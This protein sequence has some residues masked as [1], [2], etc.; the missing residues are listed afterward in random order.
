[1]SDYGKVYLVGAGIGSEEHITVRGKKLLENA[2][3]IVYDRLLNN[4]LINKSDKSK[5]FINV[6]KQ[7]SNHTFSQ[8]EINEILAQKSKSGK[9]VVRLKGGDPYVFGRGGEEALYLVERGIE[10][11]VVPGITSGVAGLCFAG[12]PI[13]HREYGSSLHLITGHRKNEEGLDFATLAKLHGTM[14][15]YM[16]LENLGNI[17]NGLINNGKNEETACAIISHGGYP[18]QKVVTSNLKNIVKDIE[19]EKINSP[20]LIVVGE[21]V[22]LREKLNFFENRPLFGKNIVVTRA[23]SQ[24]STLVQKLEELGANVIELP[25]ISIKSINQDRLKSEQNNIEK[26]TYIIFTS[27]NGVRIFMDSLLEERDVRALGNIKIF[28][29]G[30]GTAKELFKYGIKS[31]LIPSEYVGEKLYEEIKNQIKP[32]DRI[33]LPRALKARSFL[34]D[35]LSG[36]CELCE[37]PIYDTIA[38]IIEDSDYLKNLRI[39][40]VTFTSSSTVDNLVENADKS[41]LENIKNSKII[42]IGPITSKT[43]EK[44]GL[45]V[46]KEAKIYNIENLVKAILEQ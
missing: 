16:G 28:T 36:I 31:D 23:R 2:D 34:N 19:F 46:Y 33:L 37:V 25:T 21:V 35:M 5:E 38:E 9:M 11:E 4:K 27:A 24:A 15:F 3:V 40:Y 6:G 39:D 17:C 22:N 20:S 44:H 12:I 14:V 43:I 32:T 10:F 29:I 30:D 8:D 1:M 42:S 45:K 13:T 18:D 41:V 7:S 26:Y